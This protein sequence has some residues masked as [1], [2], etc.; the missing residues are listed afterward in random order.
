MALRL[1]IR[2]CEQIPVFPWRADA[3][4]VTPRS[5]WGRI[6]KTRGFD[7]VQPLSDFGRLLVLGKIAQPS[8]SQAY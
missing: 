7:E 1:L 8:M 4:V 5:S 2:R 3:R 6:S